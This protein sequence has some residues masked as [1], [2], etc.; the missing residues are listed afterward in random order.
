MSSVASMNQNSASVGP[1]PLPSCSSSPLGGS[2][3]IA[4]LI[5]PVQ[6]DS[7]ARF[8]AVGPLL[9]LLVA[10]LNLCRRLGRTV[11]ARASYRRA[12]E[13]TRQA[14]ERRFLERRLVE[15]DH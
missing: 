8:V 13:L 6:N 2:A 1:S 3:F 15:L 4:W 5:A 9:M 11:E 14:P 12:L 7:V 10:M